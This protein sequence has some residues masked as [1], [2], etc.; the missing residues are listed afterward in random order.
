MAVLEDGNLTLADWAKLHNPDGKPASV[1]KLLMKQ[2]DILDDMIFREANGVSHHTTTVEVSLPEVFFRQFNEGIA[3]TKGTHVQIQEG[4][5]MMEARTQVDRKLIRMG[6][7]KE[8]L[9]MRAAQQKVSAMR[10]KQAQTFWYGNSAATPAA[11]MGMANRLASTSAGNGENVILSEASPTGSTTSVFLIAWG[12]DSVYCTFPRGSV[13]GLEQ[14]DLGLQSVDVFNSSGAQ[15]GKMMAFEAVYGWDLGLVIEDWRQAVRIANI[16][17][18]ELSTVTGQHASPTTYATL[19]ENMIDAFYRI[20]R[21]DGVNLAFYMNRT[22]HAGLAKIAHART[23]S[24]LAIEEG[25]S[26][27]GTPR[28]WTSFM[29][30]PIRRSDSIINGETA[31][32]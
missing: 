11:Y 5:S 13:A 12:D 3:H 32:S 31:I 27:F 14:E 8:A 24:V 16:D 20:D 19:I 23:T 28:K 25:F 30:I 15:T 6:G 29:G 9:M 2:D 4:I 1:A 21:N 10:N 7:N 22:V 17:V 18:S 26:Q